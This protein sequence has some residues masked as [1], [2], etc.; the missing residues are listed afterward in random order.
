MK[1]T[2]P[3]YWDAL[4]VARMRDRCRN[5]I[6]DDVISIILLEEGPPAALEAYDAK[7]QP[8]RERVS[9]LLNACCRWL[10]GFK[11]PQEAK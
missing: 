5:W 1:P 11:L 8:K 4:M 7:M 10:D 3:D 9:R 6:A 2:I